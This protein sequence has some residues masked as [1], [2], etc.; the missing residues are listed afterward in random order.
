M[1]GSNP[2]R[3]KNYTLTTKLWRI[4]GGIDSAG[5]AYWAKSILSLDGLLIVSSSGFFVRE[6]DCNLLPDV[7]L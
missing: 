7:S 4:S 2:V 6:Q 5:I 1:L 3:D